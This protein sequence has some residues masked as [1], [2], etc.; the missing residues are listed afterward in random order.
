MKRLYVD[1]SEPIGELSELVFNHFGKTP[2]GWTGIDKLTEYAHN[3][4]FVERVFELYNYL[5]STTD[6]LIGINPSQYYKIIYKFQ[7]ASKSLDL[8]VD[9]ITDCYFYLSNYAIRVYNHYLKQI[10]QFVEEHSFVNI[11]N[12]RQA[13]KL[14]LLSAS[15]RSYSETLYCDEHTIAGEI[16]SPIIVQDGIIIARKY[17]WL[18]AT[19]LREELD[20]C[21]Y[22]E[23][24]IFIKY[25]NINKPPYTDIVGNLLT[26]TNISKYMHGFYVEIINTENKIITIDSYEAIDEVLRYF[27]YIIPLL[28]NN[29]KR[30]SLQERL[31]I[32]ILCEYYAMK[33][34]TDICGKDWRPTEYPLDINAIEN[35]DRPIVKANLKIEDTYDEQDIKKRLFEL[36]DPRVHWNW[37]MEVK[38]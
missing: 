36:N 16:Y 15:L 35:R 34:Y 14:G 29:Y 22:K 9:K 20:S 25:K 6:F 21:P 17:R 30:M 27:Q 19:E 24:N 23:I 28:S 2:M 33:P 32:K 4:Q 10:E 11:V 31:W 3:E 8:D 18:N 12:D 13:K 38:R 26:E 37:K 7:L 1:V 5:S